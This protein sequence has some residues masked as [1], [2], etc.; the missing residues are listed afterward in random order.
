MVP[1][2]LTISKT[3]GKYPRLYHWGRICWAMA[4]DTAY[5]TGICFKNW[6][7]IKATENCR[8]VYGGEELNTTSESHS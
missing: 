6:I 1:E 2:K 7:K 5:A 8:E 4:V 3:H